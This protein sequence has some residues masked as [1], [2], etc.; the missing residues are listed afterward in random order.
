[1][2]PLIKKMDASETIAR[3]KFLHRIAAG[4]KINTS[5]CCVQ[6][7]HWTTPI[8]RFAF[9]ENKQKTLSFVTK[10]FDDA[11]KIFRIYTQ[12]T[13][14]FELKLATLVRDDIAN[15]LSGLEMLAQTYSYDLKFKC[16]LATLRETVTT[17][18]KCVG[19][20][21]K[22]GDDVVDVDVVTDDFQDVR[23]LDDDDDSSLASAKVAQKP[24]SLSKKKEKKM[25]RN[26]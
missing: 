19:H 15:A 5:S 8:A 23:E 25:N 1:M 9:G 13:S 17:K 7:D 18:L 4:E 11:F 20:V 26:K 21:F 16:D 2:S 14:E 12:S 22:T 3:L 24:R 6:N 10:T